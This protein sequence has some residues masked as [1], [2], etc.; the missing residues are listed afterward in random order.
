M[1][2]RASCSCPPQ[3]RAVLAIFFHVVRGVAYLSV[4]GMGQVSMVVVFVEVLH[5]ASSD[6]V[7]AASS[8]NCFLGRGW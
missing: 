8:R 4:D 7:Q 5:K 2:P 3:H 1:R 6:S